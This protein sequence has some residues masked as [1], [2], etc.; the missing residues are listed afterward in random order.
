MSQNDPKWTTEQAVDKGKQAVEL[1]VKYR[2][3]LENRYKPGEIELLQT[4]VAEMESAGKPGQSEALVNQ[5]AQTL[6]KSETA[7]E[8]QEE[9]I[10]TRGQIKAA[11]PQADILMAFGV[12]TSAN[13]N[14][15]NQLIA[16][17]N[18]II[19]GYNLHQDWAQKEAGI[20]E[21]DIEEIQALR[22]QLI[23]A[24]G[25]LGQKK[26]ARKAKTVNKNTL[27]RTIE[28]LVT[29]TSAIGIKVFRK[30]DKAIVPLFEALIPGSSGGSPVTETTPEP[31]SAGA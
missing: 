15:Q 30:K 16:A 11:N 28:D 19:S 20:L 12:G 18:L 24:D 4:S 1:T 29:K 21:V 26:F 17:A 25:T 8:L 14:N 31:A 3:D 10:S 5:K 27:Q 6:N 22:D 2:S 9:I 7:E 23:G 13:V